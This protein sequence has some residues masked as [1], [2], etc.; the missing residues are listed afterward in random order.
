MKS[1]AYY[2]RTG[3]D[4]EF[5]KTEDKKIVDNATK[6]LLDAQKNSIAARIEKEAVD[7]YGLE[8]KARKEAE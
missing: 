3:R 1:L 6:N 2:I 8:E 7:K 5:L 4:G